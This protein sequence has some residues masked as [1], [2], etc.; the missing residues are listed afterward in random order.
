MTRTKVYVTD[1]EKSFKEEKRWLTV[2]I[3]ITLP[4]HNLDL[5]WK[6]GSILSGYCGLKIASEVHLFSEYPL[7]LK[8]MHAIS[9][10]ASENRMTPPAVAACMAPL[11]LRPL[12]AGECELED[13]F[14]MNGDSSASFLLLQMLLIMLKPS[15]RLFWRSMRTFSM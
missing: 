10:H 3:N 4:L 6:H 14:D 7:I 2:N 8:M 12:L 11:L 1:Y 13:D 9:S 5:H 15:L